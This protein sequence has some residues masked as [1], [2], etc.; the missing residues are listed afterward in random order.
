MGGW[1]GAHWGGRA[2]GPLN[3]LSLAAD[4][5]ALCVCACARACVCAR[6]RVRACVCVCVCVRARAERRGGF[7]AHGDDISD[8]AFDHSSPLHRWDLPD[9]GGGG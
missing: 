8:R 3:R 4:T 7:G 9:G 1:W 2:S 6:A 5:W